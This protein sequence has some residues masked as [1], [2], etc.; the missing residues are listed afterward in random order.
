MY[1]RKRG[2][3]GFELGFVRLAQKFQRDV[4][5][6]GA[7]PASALAFRLQARHQLAKSAAN[8]VGN[9]E[10]DEEAHGSSASV[11]GEQKISADGVE[12]LLRSLKANALAVAGEAGGAFAAATIVGD[13]DVHQAHG[14]FGRSPAGAGNS[15]DADT[16]CSAGAFANAVS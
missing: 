10:R 16:E 9:I 12:R 7:Y 2:A 5:S 8:G 3:D 1:G 15:G 11:R 4:H 14:L 6:F 13:A